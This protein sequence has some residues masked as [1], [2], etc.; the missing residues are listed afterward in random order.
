MALRGL[1]KALIGAARQ[2]IVDGI[3]GFRMKKLPDLD[4]AMGFERMCE[5]GR[6]EQRVERKQRAHEL[7]L[8]LS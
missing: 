4:A 7:E 1:G 2:H 6:I 5:G 3:G 8:S